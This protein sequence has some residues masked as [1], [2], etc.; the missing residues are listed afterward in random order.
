MFKDLNAE[1]VNSYYGLMS[2]D[3]L[4]KAEKPALLG[5]GCVTRNDIRSTAKQPWQARKGTLLC[6]LR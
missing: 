4:R 3:R 6:G 5:N 2:L 1:F